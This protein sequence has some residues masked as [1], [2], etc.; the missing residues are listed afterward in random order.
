MLVALHGLGVEVMMAIRVALGVDQR[1][2]EPNQ[3]ALRHLPPLPEVD[4][5]VVAP[6]GF[7]DV[8]YRGIGTDDV[9]R[10]I[11]EVKTAYTIDDDR[12]VLSGWSMGGI[13]VFELGMRHADQFA[14]LVALCGYSDVGLYGSSYTKRRSY[15]RPIFEGE[16]GVNYAENGKNIPLFVI[17][18]TKDSPS[19]SLAFTDR[20]TELGYSLWLELP[21]AGHNVWSYA[22]EKG[23]MLGKLAGLRRVRW[24][25][26]VTHKVFGYRHRWLYWSRIDEIDD[27]SRFARV[28]AEVKADNLVEVKTDNVNRLQLAPGGGL[29]DARRALR[30]HIG[31]ATLTVPPSPAATSAQATVRVRLQRKGGSWSVDTTP[32]PSP[33][34]TTWCWWAAPT[35]TW[36]SRGWPTACRSGWDAST[37]PPASGPTA[38]VTWAWR[39]STPTRWPRCAPSRWWRPPAAPPCSM[40]CTCP[41]CNPTT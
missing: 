11:D 18:G 30:V 6:Y 25:R 37:S 39:S 16:R 40:P 26:A 15:E 9:L 41:G 19:N 21:E 1:P 5:I 36:W 2:D 35:R 31:G 23:Y 13:G 7:G 28:D 20:Y 32:S 34:A 3:R 29:V 8:A 24:P 4:W 17:H 12:V 22:F 14:A 38:A 10:V 27:L 33:A